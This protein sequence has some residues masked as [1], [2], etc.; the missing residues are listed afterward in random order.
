[1]DNKE[2]MVS[3][4]LCNGKVVELSDDNLEKVT[5]GVNTGLSDFGEEEKSLGATNN[6]FMRE[7]SVRRIIQ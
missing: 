5:G 7:T 2:M 1:M 4:N 3:K 6:D